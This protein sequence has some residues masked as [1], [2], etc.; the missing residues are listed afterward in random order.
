MFDKKL[1]IVAFL[2]LLALSIPFTLSVLR[3]P[4]ETRTRA[5][6]GTATLSFTPIS[7]SASPLQKRVG[8]TISLDMMLDPGSNMVSFV[9]FQLSFDPTKLQLDTANPYTINDASFPINVEGPI[10]TPG[11]LGQSLSVGVDGTK[12][13]QATT[14][15]GTV[16]FKAVGPTGNTPTLVTFTDLTQALSSGPNDTYRSNVLSGTTPAS[17]LI[18]GDGSIITP[19]T[20]VTPSVSVSPTP[21]LTPGPSIPANTTTV[22]FDLLLH[23]VGA[24]GDNPNPRGN[25]LS[26]KTPLSPQRKLDVIIINSSNQPVSTASGAINY[27]A[28]NGTFKGSIAFPAAIAEGNYTVKVKTPRYLRKQVAG[29]QK[30]IPL[31]DNRMPQTELVAGDTNGDNVL[32]VIDYGAYLDC[33]YG[34]LNPLPNADANSIFNKAICQAHKPAENIDTDDNGIVDSSDYNLFLRELS[35]Q[36]GD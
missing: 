10:L 4:Q 33:G 5:A 8:D 31:K 20:S 14:K 26:N 12:V 22:T 23:G 9:K 6:T 13:I 18:S 2:F 25:S 7:S 19:G 34:V 15:A 28:S 35:V 36:N 27:D 30:I 29:V 11:K 16:K 1:L 24:A 3:K 32:D 21:S 17:I